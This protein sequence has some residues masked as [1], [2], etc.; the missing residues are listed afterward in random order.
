MQTQIIDFCHKTQGH[1]FLYLG[2]VKYM[3]KA[4]LRREAGQVNDYWGR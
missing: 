2:W 4:L 1:I 3:T